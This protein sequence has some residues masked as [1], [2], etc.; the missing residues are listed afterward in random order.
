MLL[1]HPCVEPDTYHTPP[2]TAFAAVTAHANSPGRAVTAVFIALLCCIS[3]TPLPSSEISVLEA[4]TFFRLLDQTLREI[5]QETRNYPSVMVRLDA[6]VTPHCSSGFQ[7]T[8]WQFKPIFPLLVIT[9]TRIIIRNV[10]ITMNLLQVRGKK[11]NL[12]TVTF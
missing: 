9:M 7:R 2:V 1:V 12:F 5:I 10:V 8:Y 11:W 4:L 6:E 3:T